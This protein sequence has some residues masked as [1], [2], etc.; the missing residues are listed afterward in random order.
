MKLKAIFFHIYTIIHHMWSFPQMGVPPKSSS[1]LMIGMLNCKPMML[2]YLHD[3]MES[4]YS[5]PRSVPKIRLVPTR[6]GESVQ[7]FMTLAQLSRYAMKLAR[8]IRLCQRCAFSGSLQLADFPDSALKYIHEEV[9]ENWLCPF[10][11]V[12]LISDLTSRY[13]CTCEAVAKER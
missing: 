13:A 5:K 4:P 3:E 12:F 9:P 1:I 6:W 7:I 2:G 10:Q 8:Q 11:S